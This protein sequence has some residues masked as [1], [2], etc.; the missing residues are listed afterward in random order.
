MKLKLFIS[1]F[2]KNEFK[3]ILGKR[4]S[5]FWILLAVFLCS[6]GALEFSRAGMS[7]LSYKMND[8]FIN[9]VEVSSNGDFG[10]FRAE[11]AE[12][13]TCNRFGIGACEENNFQFTQLY[14][15]DGGKIGVVGRT[16]GYESRLLERILDD[17][18]TV[19]RRSTPMKDNDYGW[20]VTQE[21]MENLGYDKP[22]EYP[23]FL[24]I[25]MKGDEHQISE[26]R[27]PNH[28]DGWIAFPIPIIAVV[29]Q[30]P[31][32]LDFMT[33]MKYFEQKEKKRPSPFNISKQREYYNDIFF[34]STDVEGMNHTVI[35]IMNESGLNFDINPDEIEPYNESLRPAY[36]MRVVVYDTVPALLNDA[37][38]KVVTSNP[39]IIRVF[40]YKFRDNVDKGGADYLS[41]MFDDLSKVSDFAK[42]AKSEYSV[43]IDMTQIEAKN[44]FNTFNLLATVLCIAIMILS[45]LFLAIFLW[46]LI[47]SHFRAI[48]KNLGTIMAFGL[49]NKTIIH[50]YRSVFMKMVLYSI[51][52]AL[53]ILGVTELLMSLLGITQEGGIHYITLFD[54]WVWA[55][56]IIIP[57]LTAIVVTMTMQR[58]LQSTPGDLIFERNN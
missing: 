38:Q 49:P 34:V 57:I 32:L 16:I 55:L 13:E 44:N 47:D 2:V 19:V 31:D 42:W 7:Y 22:K 25:A 20:I 9:W 30:L 48:S 15:K 50:I 41:F 36:K 3:S 23:I 28:G 10:E 54:W 21:I 18:N 51:G 53:L 1:T 11:T 4:K 40:E 56:I 58:K 52:L 35:Q 24:N 33:P 12:T 17:D 26:W 37:A 29:K 5:N 43:R 39:E 27:I 46:F 6:L 8:P 45:V 14:N